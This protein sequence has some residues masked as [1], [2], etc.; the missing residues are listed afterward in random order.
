MATIRTGNRRRQRSMRREIVRQVRARLVTRKARQAVRTALS[1][2]LVVI[3]GARPG[4]DLS[5]AFRTA[6]ARLA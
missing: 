6:R 4:D 2:T 5:R 1:G 3:H